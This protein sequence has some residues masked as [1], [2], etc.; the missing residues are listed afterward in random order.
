MDKKLPKVYANKIDKDLKNNE[1]VYYSHSNTEK[2]E[3]KKQPRTLVEEKY[4][5]SKDQN[6]IQKINAIFN[7]PKY[8]YKANVDI[9]LKSGKV[10]KKIIGKNSTHIITID[11][12][13]IPISEI[14]DIDFSE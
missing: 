7:S 10:S 13:L 5:I 11:N 12:E 4:K 2:I 8:V 9:E 6:I 14:V 3:E 1:R